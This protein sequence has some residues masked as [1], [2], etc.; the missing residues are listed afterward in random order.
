VIVTVATDGAGM[1]GTENAKTLARDFPEGFDEVAAGQVFGEH[2][3]GS[4]TDHLLEL[5]MR[6][7]ERIFNLGY[8]TWVEQQGVPIEEFEARRRQDFWQDIRSVLPEWDRLIEEFN[9]RTGALEA[10]GR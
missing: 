1:Y 8:Y 5:S 4:A 10:I 6:D 7:R 9:D 3:L 2:L